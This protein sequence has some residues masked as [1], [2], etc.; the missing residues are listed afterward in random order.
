L[1][2]PKKID[3]GKIRNYGRLEEQELLSQLRDEKMENIL[4]ELHI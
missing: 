2:K 1:I 4:G 3:F